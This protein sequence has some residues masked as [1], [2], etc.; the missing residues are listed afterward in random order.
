MKPLLIAAA[1]AVALTGVA[2]SPALAGTCASNFKVEGVPM[3]SAMT[4]RS[5]Q[6]FPKVA[7]KTALAQ[8]AAAVAAE[9]FHGI[10][11]DHQLGAISALQE[12]TG[13]GRPQT[14][15]VVVRRSGKGSRVDAVFTVQQGQVAGK[16]YIRQGMCRVVAAA[17]E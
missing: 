4:F 1:A 15:R 16:D 13:T 11:V 17:G 14:L 7:P 5:S 12:T 8:L 9:G 10:D 3:L 6:T 2:A